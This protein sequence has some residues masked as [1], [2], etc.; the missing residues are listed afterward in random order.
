MKRAGGVLA[1]VAAAATMSGCGGVGGSPSTVTRTVTVTESAGASAET[2]EPADTAS[3]S[4]AAVKY[5]KKIEGDVVTLTVSEVRD[6]TNPQYPD[7]GAWA[8]MVE[9]CA[10]DDLGGPISPMQH[11]VL[12]DGEGGTYQPNGTTGGGMPSPQL[13]PGSV[14]VAKGQCRKGNLF[15]DAPSG[16][17]IT[18][19]EALDS[20]G[21]S[22]GTWSK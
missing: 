11:F 9:I 1:V 16:A 14:S 20:D 7:Q 3:T 17:N 10:T 12:L 22:M 8:A 2:G 4:A 21:E 18:G 13:D 5:G 19:A 15:F 6:V